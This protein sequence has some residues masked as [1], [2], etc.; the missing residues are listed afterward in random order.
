MMVQQKRICLA[1]GVVS[2]PDGCPT[3]TRVEKRLALLQQ[4]RA[5]FG[6]RWFTAR[7]AARA[8]GLES[9]LNLSQPLHQLAGE[10]RVETSYHC[11][12]RVKYRVKASGRG[13]KQ[14]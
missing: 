8:L 9:G 11:K 10:G 2:A 13:R 14:G 12:A 6:R 7:D 1:C 5:M 4:L 3:C